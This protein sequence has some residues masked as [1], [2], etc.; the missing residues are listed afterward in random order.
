V[1]VGC[2]FLLIWGLVDPGR[3]CELED[4][5]VVGGSEPGGV[6]PAGRFQRLGSLPGGV[7]GQA[8]VDVGRRMKADAPVPMFMIVEFDEFGDELPRGLQGVE[9]FREHRRLL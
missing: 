7:A 4:L 2:G 1:I 3:C 9:P 6:P 8:V 5:G